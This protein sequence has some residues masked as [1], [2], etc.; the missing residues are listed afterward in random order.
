M[1]PTLEAGMR[2]KVQACIQACEQGVPRATIIDGRVP[3]SMLLEIF[4][5][6]GF[7]TMVMEDSHD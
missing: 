5:D 6:T 4:T 2:P 7:G 3:H 1:L